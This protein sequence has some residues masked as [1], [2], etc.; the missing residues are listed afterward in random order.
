MIFIRE[1][2]N[3]LVMG[4]NFVIGHNP[5]LGASSANAAIELCRHPHARIELYHINKIVT[6][7]PV[8]T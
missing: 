6:C 8:F 3:I 2:Y 4:N 1:P 5:V 7:F